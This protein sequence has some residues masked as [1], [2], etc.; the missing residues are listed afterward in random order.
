MLLSSV[1]FSNDKSSLITP[2]K[3]YA[4]NMLCCC[5]ENVEKL[6]TY[7]Q[8]QRLYQGS[9]SLDLIRL[10]GPFH[11]LFL[12]NASFRNK[13]MT[14]F[15]SIQEL[16]LQS[17][18]SFLIFCM[19]NAKLFWH[20]FQ[21]TLFRNFELH[22][23]SNSGHRLF[24]FCHLFAITTWLLLRPLAAKRQVYQIAFHLLCALAVSNG[25]LIWKWNQASLTLENK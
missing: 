1:F 9:Y 7:D 13:I 20:S 19:L 18:S 21:K 14:L 11:L 15:D 24:H 16:G 4:N 23:K 25:L 8:G 17:N 2:L 12:L 22:P 10:F 5:G 3:T 6:E